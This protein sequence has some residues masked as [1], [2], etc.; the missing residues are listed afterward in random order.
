MSLGNRQGWAKVGLQ[1]EWKQRHAGCE[2]YNGFINTNN[3]NKKT[4]NTNK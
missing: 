1:F 4:N 2:Y 3:N